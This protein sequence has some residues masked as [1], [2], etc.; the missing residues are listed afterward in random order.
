MTCVEKIYQRYTH[1]LLQL[2]IYRDDEP[3]DDAPHMLQNFDALLDPKTNG[4]LLD[5]IE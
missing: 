3:V 1:D 2:R 5:K 4:A